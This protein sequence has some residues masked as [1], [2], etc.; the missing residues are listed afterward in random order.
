MLYI[1]IVLLVFGYIYLFQKVAYLEAR[2]DKKVS[3]EPPSAQPAAKPAAIVKKPAPKPMPA[4]LPSAPAERPAPLTVDRNVEFKLG[5]KFF[6]IIGALAVIIGVSFF[7][8][9]AFE[10]NLISETM[11]VVLGVVAGFALLG[12]GEFARRRFPSYGGVVTGGGLGV[13]YLSVYAGFNFYALYPYTLAFLFMIGITAVGVGLSIRYD[14]QPLAGFALLGGFLSP[15][16]LATKEL[17]VHALF[18]YLILLN[19]G[20]L[21]VAWKKQWSLVT[22]GSA[23][24]TFIVYLFWFEQFY[25]KPQLLLA[26]VYLTLFFVL[27]LGTTLLYN[28][29]QGGLRRSGEYIFA[30]LTPLLYLGLSYALVNPHYPERMGI[31]ALALSVLYFLFAVLFYRDESRPL[32]LRE[33]FL[34]LGFLFFALFIPIQFE[35]FVITQAWAVEAVIVAVIGFLIGSKT[36]RVSSAVLFQLVVIRFLVTMGSLEAARAFFSTRVAV[37]LFAILA[38]FLIVA[39][40]HRHKASLPP[41]EFRQVTSLLLLEGY[42]LALLAVYLEIGDFFKIYWIPVVFALAALV[43]GWVALQIRQKALRYAVY[44]TFLYVAL[45]L[46]V[47]E[48]SVTIA[49]YEPVFN[50]RVFVFLAGALSMGAFALLLRFRASTVPPNE[51]RIMTRLLSV[52]TYGL[53]LWMISREVID[54]FTQRFLNSTDSLYQD[55]TRYVN[56]RNAMLS[57][58]WTIYTVLILMF[59]VLIKSATARLSAIIFFF[60]IILK[61]F[62]YD[63]QTLNNLYRFISFITLGIILLGA[64]YLYNRYKDRIMQFIQADKARPDADAT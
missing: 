26:E 52:S 44:L 41:D 1:F 49:T 37:A 58:A 5:S 42:F 4:S 56:L 3:E 39:L 38:A 54:Y 46:L 30:V 24:G 18:V 61:V 53:L 20:M 11:R 62:L 64:G 40:Y 2:L 17:N 36:L 6:T 29:V 48:T 47:R 33:L 34:L 13:L 28:N 19:L 43:A 63:S 21:F 25:V 59:G 23:A 55:R 31:F 10:N 45:H 12:V 22:Y 50:S 27:F 15:L 8:R 60:V 7:L 57:V 14:L 51:R 16:L 9:Y 35:K 32:P